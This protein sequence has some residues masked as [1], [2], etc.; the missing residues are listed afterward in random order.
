MAKKPK[1]HEYIEAQ[2]K[3]CGKS[4]K[5]VA[6]EAG[7]KH[8]NILSMIKSNLT[9]LPVPRVNAL[10]DSLG[11]SR[12]RLMRLVLAEDYPDILEAIEHSLGKVIP[13]D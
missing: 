9:K 4:Q 8:P 6:A 1:V 5:Q 3:L 2:L 12:V 7:F 13:D 11:V 10:A